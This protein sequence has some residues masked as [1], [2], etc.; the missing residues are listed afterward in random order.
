MKSLQTLIVFL[1]FKITT[2]LGIPKDTD[3]IAAIVNNQIILNSDIQ[4]K[5]QIMKY[6]LC[7]TIACVFQDNQLY[8]IIL[9]RLI[10]DN[11]ILQTAIQ[12][13][14]KIDPDQ[15]HNIMSS[16]AYSQNMT[17]NQ[18]H[19]YINNI[20]LNYEKYSLE[21]YHNII[22]KLMCSYAIYQ[23][24]HYIS[25]TEIKNI[26]Q[27]LN[28]IDFNKQFKLIHI[29]IDVPIQTSDIQMNELENLAK[30]I[31]K[32]RS[33][34]QD[35]HTIIKA[36]YKNNIIPRIIIN[37]TEWTTWKNIPVIF[38]QY[39]E[40]IK[41]GD[42]IGPIRSHDGIHILEIQDI[43]RKECIFPVIRVKIN[44]IV[45]KNTA[46][47]I[48][49]Q[50]QLLKIKKTIED[51]NTTFSTIIKE[52]NKDFYSHNYDNPV[53]WIDLD[54]L[55]PL[56]QRSL[57]SL[58]KDQ[59]SIPIY[60]TEGWLLLKLID[61]D[62]LSYSTIIYERSYFYLLNQKFNDILNNWIQE[63]KSKAYINIIQ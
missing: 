50:K 63:L 32:K 52:K 27:K 1:L 45:A 29:I 39:L 44:D 10:I 30:L 37:K 59:I 49:I 9:N 35:I 33:L 43:R 38:D 14:I 28:F 24:D 15:F 25:P 8:N 13:N 46:N 58:K 19:L 55:D 17:L 61:I 3:H 23:N 5:I 18:F 53:K 4:N 47:C 20:G 2:V 48:D 36:Y 40:T 21:I 51:N 11:L 34:N 16:I 60:T 42:I 12:E 31:V 7:D 22:K 26:A 54:S 57:L 41:K 6:D 56:I 62:K